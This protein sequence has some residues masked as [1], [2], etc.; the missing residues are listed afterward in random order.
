MDIF[1]KEEFLK[2]IF[3]ASLQYINT[4]IRI[5]YNNEFKV[6]LKIISNK[7]NEINGWADKIDN[8][9]TVGIYW[10]TYH[11]ID[12]FWKKMLTDD[13]FLSLLTGKTH[14]DNKKEISEEYYPLMLIISL[15]CVIFHELGH[16]VNGHVDYIKDKNENSMKLFEAV[17]KEEV[18]SKKLGNIDS[19]IWQAIEWNADDFGATNIIGQTTYRDNIEKSVIKNSE[20]GLWLTFIAQVVVYS[21]MYMGLEGRDGLEYKEKKHL[22][23][24]FRLES[25]RKTMALAYKKFNGKLTQEIPDNIY[26]MVFSRIE[27][28]VIL[29]MKEEYNPNINISIENNKDTLDF[30]HREYYKEVESYYLNHLPN[31]LKKYT[32]VR[33]V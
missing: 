3:E 6:K 13:V 32:F 25:I 14:I 16:I 18:M 22:P 28:W 19:K 15:K 26:N 33:V 29:F 17:D 4:N 10:G 8:I 21:L 2:G 20:H 5:H 9:Y 12:D 7:V 24:R 1:E 23:L 31:E 11:W 30:N 27:E